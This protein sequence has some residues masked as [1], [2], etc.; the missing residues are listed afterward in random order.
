M[1]GLRKREESYKIDHV[2]K[3]IELL[4][5]L[6]EPVSAVLTR[7]II[8]IDLAITT[9]G[10]CV[11]A[12]DD[13]GN[14]HVQ[15]RSFQKNLITDESLVSTVETTIKEDR[16]HSGFCFIR[17]SGLG[18]QLFVFTPRGVF[19]RF[20]IRDATQPVLMEQ[21]QLLQ[22]NQTLAHI[23]RLFGG[24]S[25]VLGDNSGTTRILFTSRDT[26][27][28]TKDGLATKITATF[29]SRLNETHQQK[30]D[31]GIT[32]ISASPRSRLFAVAS[33]DG[34]IRLLQATNHSKI[35]EIN[36]N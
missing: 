26:S 7:P 15:K 11:A 17:V 28:S 36:S 14:I 1:G 20:V 23:T 2:T 30:K 3:K 18:D 29:A 12:L 8:D 6:D 10:F 13:R 31:R 25:F 16:N 19:K 24:S 9:N 33:A 4:A 5:Y 27:V 35:A 32:A 22:K 34:F 21:R